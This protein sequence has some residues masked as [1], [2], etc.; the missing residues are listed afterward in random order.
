MKVTCISKMN[1]HG[2]YRNLT[3]Q[4]KAYNNYSNTDSKTDRFERTYCQI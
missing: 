3:F 4:V 2:A 1:L